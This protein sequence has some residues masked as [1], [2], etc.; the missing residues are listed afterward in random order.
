[1]TATAMRNE[2][3]TY[4]DSIPYDGLVCVKPILSLLATEGTSTRLERDGYAIEGDLTV[5]ETAVLN[6]GLKERAAHPEK[7][8]EWVPH[9]QV[10]KERGL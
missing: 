3:K 4:I 2:L 10:S 6:E 5:E 1:M 8:I 9:S 7:Y